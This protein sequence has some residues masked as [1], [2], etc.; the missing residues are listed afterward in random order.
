MNFFDYRIK[1]VSFDNELITI[2]T[3]DGKKASLPLRNFPK[4]YEAS[5]AIKRSF[6]IVGGGY[7]LHWKDL[8]EDLCAAG[9]FEKAGYGRGV[10]RKKTA[11]KSGRTHQ[12][13]G[14]AR[15][16]ISQSGR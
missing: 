11:G 5:D 15:N 2:E 8:D 10:R 16:R 4:L 7:A 12:K 14:L 1:K 9:F 3:A 13:G 6:E